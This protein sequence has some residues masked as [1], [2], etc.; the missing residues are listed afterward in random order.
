[1]C[2]VCILFLIKNLNK[3]FILILN[4][5]IISAEYYNNY[6]I[7]LYII[8][9]SF[10]HIFLQKFDENKNTTMFHKVL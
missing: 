8:L 2:I 4:W 9:F 1:M 5:L 7:I 3:L 10:A 6:Y